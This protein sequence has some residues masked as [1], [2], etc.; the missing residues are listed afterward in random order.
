[1]AHTYNN[2]FDRVYSFQNL[3]KAYLKARKN[4]R[5]KEDV[6]LF[7]ANLEE[8]LIQLQNELIYKTYEPGSY[9]EFY[10]Y[11]PKTRL[12]MA[13]P[14]KDRVLH[15]ALCNVIEPI[16][17]RMFI[18]HSFACR[19]GKGTHAGVNCTGEFLR[20]AMRKYGTVYC[21][22]ADVS[23]YFQSISH[24]VLRAILRRKISCK[25]TLWL[26]DKIINSTSQEGDINPIGLPVGNLTSQLFANVYLNELDYYMKHEKRN[27]FYIRYMDDFLVL[28]PDKHYL[29]A[30]WQDTA[31]FLQDELALRL[32]QKTAIFP[33][34][35]DIDF[36]GYRI[37]P[38]RKI[39]RKGSVKRI[40]RIVKRFDREY[41]AKNIGQD[42][43]RAVL[44]SWLGHAKRADVPILRQ[45]ILLKAHE[46]FGLKGLT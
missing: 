8:N 11:D 13:A 33:I 20:K 17:E 35:Q 10:V 24:N 46:T 30:L 42:K 5:Y 45:K 18:Y 37:W 27:E 14:F 40:K 6:L 2:L 34:S 28:H 38:H 1:M 22:K 39:L 25:D 26:I 44:A 4:K 21:F 29:H 32:N 9:R 43:I 19:R 36:L 3:F 7:T 31:A 41:R 23:K 12:V 15:H 16:Y